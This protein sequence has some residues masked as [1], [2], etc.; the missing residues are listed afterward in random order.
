MLASAVAFTAM[1][2]LAHQAAKHCPWQMVALARTALATIFAAILVKRAGVPFAVWSPPSLW[3]RSL[4]GSTSLLLTFFALKNLSV[5][6]AMTLTHM[7]PI[8]I[9]FLSWPMLGQSPGAGTWFAALAGVAGVG[10][11]EQSQ[12]VSTGVGGHPLAPWAAIA[13]SFCTAFAMMGLHRVKNLDPRAVVVHFSAVGTAFTLVACLVAGGGR[14]PSV[15]VDA[16]LMMLILGTGVFATAGQLLMTKAYAGAP[17]ARVAVVGLTQV[18]L[19]LAAD[20]ALGDY[21]FSP[22]ALLGMG[23]IIAPTA[24]VLATAPRRRP[25]PTEDAG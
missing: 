20:V 25:E 7:S 8:W 21:A 17:P 3:M 24:W 14:L 5:A 22:I 11:M 12:P 23:L 10:L 19:A 1:G 13:G 2:T 4:A 18:P 15:P 6:H 16:G 9:A